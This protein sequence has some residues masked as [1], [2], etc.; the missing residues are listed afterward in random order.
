MT[1]WED[2]FV[3]RSIKD[4]I[5]L[6][7]SDYFKYKDYMYNL[8]E[9][10]LKNNMYA[11]ISNYNKLQLDLFNGYVF[12]DIDRMR[13]YPILKLIFAINNLANDNGEKTKPL[14]VYNANDLLI[15]LND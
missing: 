9:N 6:S 3:P 13:H 12:S 5:I 7:L 4:N 14:I 10:N 8:S 2:E 1:D 11:A 15:C